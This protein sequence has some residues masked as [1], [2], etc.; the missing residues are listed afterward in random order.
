MLRINLVSAA[1]ALGLSFTPAFAE[2]Q[3]TFYR[4][5]NTYN[6]SIQV[7]GNT[8]RLAGVVVETREDFDLRVHEGGYVEGAFGGRPVNF[9]VSKRLRERLVARLAKADRLATGVEVSTR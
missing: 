3:N 7:E 5:G 1:I 8:I 6:Y 2:A 9:R 4:D